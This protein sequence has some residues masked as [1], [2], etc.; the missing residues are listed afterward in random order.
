MQILGEKTIYSFSLL[1]GGDSYFLYINHSSTYKLTDINLFFEC[2]SLSGTVSLKTLLDNSILYKGKPKRVEKD[3]MFHIYDRE[4]T[5]FVDGNKTQQIVR[6][7]FRVKGGLKYFLELPQESYDTGNVEFFKGWISTARFTPKTDTAHIDSFTLFICPLGVFD[8]IG[9]SIILYFQELNE[10]EYTILPSFT[11]N[12]Y[13]P[14]EAI[15]HMV[16][17]IT[18]NFNCSTRFEDY[19]HGGFQS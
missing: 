16:S 2:F 18:R 5:C 4:L 7:D 13:N 12:K 11:I 17:A 3:R 6:E 10:G 14:S 9:K 1:T 19:I 15:N 8:S